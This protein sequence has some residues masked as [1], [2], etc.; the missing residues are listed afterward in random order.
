[1][2]ISSVIV[3]L[4]Q[5]QP[6]LL[7]EQLAGDHRFEVVDAADLRVALTVDTESARADRDAYRF[8]ESLEIVKGVQPVFIA[9]SEGGEIRGKTIRCTGAASQVEGTVHRD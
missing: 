9:Y 2:G 4:Y 7:T 3:N 5:P 1:M 6:E 8:L